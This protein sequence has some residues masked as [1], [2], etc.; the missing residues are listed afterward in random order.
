[1]S[2]DIWVVVCFSRHRRYNSAGLHSEQLLQPSYTILNS[3]PILQK[4]TVPSQRNKIPSPFPASRISGSSVTSSS[5][6][7]FLSFLWASNSI[8]SLLVSSSCCTARGSMKCPSCSS[9][10]KYRSWDAHS[11]KYR[12]DSWTIITHV[13]GHA[14]PHLHLLKLTTSRFICRGLTVVSSVLGFRL[15]HQRQYVLC[16]IVKNQ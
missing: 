12:P 4:P 8:K 14:N 3:G 11:W 9:S 15:Q 16:S 1:M 6:C 13:I 5:S 10:L 2:S 7:L